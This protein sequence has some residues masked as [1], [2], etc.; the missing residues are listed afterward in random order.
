MLISKNV[1]KMTYDKVADCVIFFFLLLDTVYLPAGSKLSTGRRE[2]IVLRD[3]M[4]VSFNPFIGFHQ[5][6]FSVFSHLWH[7]GF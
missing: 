7:T 4:C 6:S 5:H 1:F 2:G 3:G